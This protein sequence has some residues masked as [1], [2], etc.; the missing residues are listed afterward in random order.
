M[1]AEKSCL[2]RD[3]VCAVIGRAGDDSVLLFHRVGFP[4]SEG[5]QFPQGGIDPGKGLIAELRRELRE[6]IG[7][8]DIEVIRIAPGT[9]TY[10]FPPNVEAKGGKA[11]YRGQR[12]RWVLAELKGS[13]SAI[14]FSY[15]PAEFDRFE[16]VAPGEAL[17]RIVSFKRTVYEKAL[18]TLGLIK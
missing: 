18:K 10:D 9:F 16:W 4:P 6:E 17:Q 12:Q 14:S 5:W 15:Q 11:R 13:E 8:D 7:T 3:N 1:G 2:Y